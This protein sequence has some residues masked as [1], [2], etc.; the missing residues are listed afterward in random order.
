MPTVAELKAELATH[1]LP[2]TGLKAELMA[3]LAGAQIKSSETPKKR[4]ATPA[5]KKSSVKK[6]KTA[7]SPCTAA[8]QLSQPGEP[9]PLPLA[10]AP[11]S[12]AGER[13]ADDAS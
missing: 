1:G 2:T 3:R 4:K 11:S 10:S 8:A 7:P 13:A 9:Q 6:A 12:R 5:K